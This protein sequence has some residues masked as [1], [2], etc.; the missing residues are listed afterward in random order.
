MPTPTKAV[1]LSKDE[2]TRAAVE[3]EVRAEIKWCDDQGTKSDVVPTSGYSRRPSLTSSPIIRHSTNFGSSI[4]WHS[5]RF[6]I[7]WVDG[8]TF[9]P[10][11]NAV[12]VRIERSTTPMLHN[13]SGLKCSQVIRVVA[14]DGRKEIVKGERLPGI[15]YAEF[16]L[17][18]GKW[19]HFQFC[20]DA[21]LE[22]DKATRDILYKWTLLQL[23]MVAKVVPHIKPP[24]P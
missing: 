12:Y 5:K 1:L 4:N 21:E 9:K 2:A 18:D 20:F 13:F 22:R 23:F 17:S 6:S 15:A 16:V 24:P 10:T 3:T 14:V 11:G 8:T 7:R 19:L